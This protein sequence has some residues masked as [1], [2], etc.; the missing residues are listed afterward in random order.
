V[1]ISTAQHLTV[2]HLFETVLFIFD[3]LLHIIFKM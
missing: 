3:N 1:F 2:R